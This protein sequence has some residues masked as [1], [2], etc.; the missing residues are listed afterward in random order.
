MLDGAALVGA[1]GEGLE[2]DGA[3]DAGLHGPDRLEH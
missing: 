1:G 2:V 3:P